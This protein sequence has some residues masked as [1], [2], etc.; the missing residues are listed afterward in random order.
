MHTANS[1]LGTGRLAMFSLGLTFALFGALPVQAN[2]DAPT[3][4]TVEQAL[5]SRWDKSATANSPRATLTL[6]SVKFGKPAMATAQEYQV[7]GVPKGAMVTPAVIDFTVRTYY[8]TETQ[9]VQ[10]VRAASV[11]KDKM[12]EWAV[13]TGSPKGQ[14]ATTKEAPVK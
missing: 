9:V 5:K 8:S 12:D 1:I 4:A 14:D 7:D 11:Y 13:M 3:R 10:R 6:N 2:P